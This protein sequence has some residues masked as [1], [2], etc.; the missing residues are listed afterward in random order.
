MRHLLQ[1]RRCILH[2]MALHLLITFL[3]Y[4]KTLCLKI[5]GKVPY[6]IASEA[7]YV[8]KSSLKMPRMVHFGELLKSITLRSNSVTRQVS[9]DRRQKLVENAKIQM[10]HYEYHFQTVQKVFLNCPLGISYLKFFF[11]FLSEWTFS[12]TGIE[13]N[14]VKLPC[15]ISTSKSEDD[16]KLVLWFKNGSN[17]PIYT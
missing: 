15:N 13:G 2:L 3:C 17:R 12:V 8:Y 9:F 10:R 16:V 6:N 5:T 7:S 11:A 4:T 1:T 14:L